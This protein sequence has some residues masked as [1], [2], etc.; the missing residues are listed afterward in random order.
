MVILDNQKIVLP[1][2]PKE[3]AVLLDKCANDW[4]AVLSFLYEVSLMDGNMLDVN[5]VSYEMKKL[6]EEEK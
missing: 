5:K 1:S 6:Y 2:N 3:L 4:K